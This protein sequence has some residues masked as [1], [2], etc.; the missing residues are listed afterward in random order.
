MNARFG[1]FL[2]SNRVMVCVLMVLGSVLFD[3]CTESIPSDTRTE[4]GAYADGRA[5]EGVSRFPTGPQ[6][7]Y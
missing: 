2:S 5:N 1:L 4:M 3:G 7:G 6:S